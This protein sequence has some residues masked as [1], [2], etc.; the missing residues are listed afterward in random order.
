MHLTCFS[1]KSLQLLP[2]HSLPAV[3]ME[4]ILL[5]TFFRWGPE[6]QVAEVPL[7]ICKGDEF[8]IGRDVNWYACPYCQFSVSSLTRT[9]LIS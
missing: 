8:Y 1:S 6:G 3:Q 4:E 9:Q 7:D 2:V 5:G